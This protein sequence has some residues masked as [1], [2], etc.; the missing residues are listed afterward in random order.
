[1]NYQSAFTLT[2]PNPAAA[3]TWSYRGFLLPHPIAF[4]YNA[5]TDALGSS[6]GNN[7]LN[8]QITGATV[9]DKYTTFKELANRWRLAYMSVTIYQDGP[10]LANQGM[11]ACCQFPSN[12]TR[13]NP[14]IVTQDIGPGAMLASV[15]FP[16]L[17]SYDITTYP[18]FT[19]C[20]AYPNAYMN[21]GKEGLYCP[22]KLTRT[23]QHWHSRADEFVMTTGETV[24]DSAGNTSLRIATNSANTVFPIGGQ[25]RFFYTPATAGATS[26]YG[27]MAVP[28]MGNDTFASINFVNLAVTTSLKFYIRCGLEIQCLPGS[29][30]SPHLKLSP[31]ADERALM[32]YFAIARELKDAYPA[33]YNDAGKI[34]DEI[35]GAAGPVLANISTMG[36]PGMIIG[37]IGTGIKMIGDTIRGATKKKAAEAAT[38]GTAASTASAAQVQR[39]ADAVHGIPPPPAVPMPTFK[40]YGHA[41]RGVTVD[42]LNRAIGGLKQRPRGRMPFRPPPGKFQRRPR[43]FN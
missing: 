22:L 1:M 26:V 6:A 15:I 40:S 27:G 9:F 16:H 35:S 30:M 41:S 29:T 21:K 11:V 33:D 25:V 17:E 18:D 8:T 13:Y 23:H 24:N 28:A 34:W 3:G 36:L 31:P 12:P 19:T 20:P 38:S 42:D 7:F 14:S 39:V 2:N 32:T 37:G 10:D 5:T 43:H 4:M